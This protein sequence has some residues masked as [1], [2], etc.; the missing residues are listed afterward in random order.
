ML[1]SIEINI[2]LYTKRVSLCDIE[3]YLYSINI[4]INVY[5]VSRI[6]IYSVEFYRAFHVI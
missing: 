3:D 2:K 6:C 1:D 5:T 4:N